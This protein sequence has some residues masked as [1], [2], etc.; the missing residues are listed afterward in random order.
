MPSAERSLAPR[1]RVP[2]APLTTLG[3]GGDA[4]WFAQ[5]TTLDDI[6]A[7]QRWCDEHGVMLF[8]LGGGSNVIV[9]SA[10]Q[11]PPQALAL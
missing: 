11:S 3:V 2:L 1:A 9:P 7:A 8:A 10:A 5:A 4:R 6:A